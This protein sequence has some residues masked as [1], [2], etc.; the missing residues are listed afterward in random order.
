MSKAN[1]VG[2][3]LARQRAAQLR[4]EQARRARRNRLLAVY[5]SVLGVI[6]VAVAVAFAVQ[7]A[8]APKTPA[9][10]PVGAVADTTGGI[11][12]ADGMAIPLG[13]ADAKVK[14]TVYEDARCSACKSYET[15]FTPAY[16]QLI[17]NG[18]LELLIHPVTL[19]DAN[20][21]GSGSLHAGNAFACAQDAGHFEAYHDIIYNNQPAESTDSFASDAT[22]IALAKQV[23]G[24]DGK[25][26]E[27]CVNSHRYFDW[28]RQNYASL[29]KI[30]NNQ[31]ST[32]T[33]Y[34]NG[35]AFTL[36]TAS[37][38]T[39]AQ[40]AFIAAIDKLAG[41]NPSASPS[42]S[43]GPSTSASP[44]AAA[45]SGASPAPTPSASKS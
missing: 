41:V 28:V 25:T 42:A 38:A 24:L 12:S 14:L 26:F 4:Q 21:N 18:T 10:V 27:N 2:K 9:A 40:T 29:N 39:A 23:P 22:L 15:T 43:S 20:T 34:A 13:N 31:P 1:K 45:G 19:I 44:S 6:V 37:Q 33:I 35:K 5:G 32:P 36:P 7:A 11:S 8:T 17:Q 16:K 30:T 3:E